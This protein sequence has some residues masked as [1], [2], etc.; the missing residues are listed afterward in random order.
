MDGYRPTRHLKISVGK[1]AVFVQLNA[2]KT[3]A[4][5]WEN[6]PIEAKA[7]LW[8]DEIYFY[9][10]PAMELEEGYKKDVVEVGDAAYWPNGPCLCLFFGMTPISRDGKI[11]PASAVNVFGKIVDDPSVLK[12]VKEGDVVRIEAA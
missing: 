8:G 3:A 6:L 4:M 9:V 2:S 10:G 5:I 12:H 7:E 1:Q 11:K